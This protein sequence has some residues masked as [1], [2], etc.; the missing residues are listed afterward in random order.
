MQSFEDRTPRYE[1]FKPLESVTS[2]IRGAGNVSTYGALL[3]PRILSRDPEL[4]CF[5]GVHVAHSHGSFLCT[6]S[7]QNH[8]DGI[9]IQAEADCRQLFQTKVCA[10]K[11]HHV[12]RSCQ[13]HQRQVQDTR[14]SCRCGHSETKNVADPKNCQETRAVKCQCRLYQLF[15]STHS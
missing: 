12:L 14:N 15:Q 10:P 1:V 8:A 6:A 11:N 9:R 5:Q 13:T 7:V 4:S 3:V 2:T